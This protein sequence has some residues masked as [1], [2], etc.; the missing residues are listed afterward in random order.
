MTFGHPL[1]VILQHSNITF[2]ILIFVF[3]FYFYIC[4]YV[5]FLFFLG[6]AKKRKRTQKKRKPAVVS[7]NLRL[8]DRMDVAGKP[9]LSPH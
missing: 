1:L 6:N 3:N 4:V 5:H 9:A 2:I 7:S 8:Q